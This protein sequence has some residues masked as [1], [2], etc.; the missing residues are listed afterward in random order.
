MT[1]KGHNSPCDSAMRHELRREE[2]LAAIHQQRILLLEER[3]HRARAELA[4]VLKRVK[5]IRDGLSLTC[6]KPSA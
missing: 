5:T 6:A 2:N 4:D 3:T 1:I